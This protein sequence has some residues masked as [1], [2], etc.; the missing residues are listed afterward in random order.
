MLGTA[1]AA[2]PHTANLSTPSATLVNSVSNSSASTASST[3]TP[4]PP[5]TPTPNN[6]GGSHFAVLTGS[7]STT[8]NSHPTPLNIPS[9]ERI[10]KKEKQILL[11][12]DGK[13]KGKYYLFWF[14]LRAL[15]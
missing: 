2:A 7:A 11:E 5:T 9:E 6:T 4:P 1:A 13:T 3:S 8:T 14:I 10:Y 12:F 15:I